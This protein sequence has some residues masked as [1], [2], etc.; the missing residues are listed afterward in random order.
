MFR[1]IITNFAKKL[2]YFWLSK[3]KYY[4]YTKPKKMK[5]T[6]LISVLF[7]LTLLSYGQGAYQQL[8]NQYVGERKM[9]LQWLNTSPT[10]KCK[11]GK[12][13]ISQEEG[14]FTL[15]IKGS[16]YKNDNEYVSIEGTI[17]PVSATEFNFSGKI[18]SRVSYIFNGEPCVREGSFNFKKYKGRAFYRL[19]EKTNCDGSSVDYIDIY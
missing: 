6:I 16:Q 9:T 7:L 18:I 3:L 10:K 19:Q 12:V 8:I 13:T 1:E 4:F 14:S 2:I 17:E 5:K 11:P 15:T